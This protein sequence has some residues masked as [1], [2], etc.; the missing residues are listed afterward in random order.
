MSPF[1]LPPL[2]SAALYSRGIPPKSPTSCTRQVNFFFAK[3]VQVSQHAPP[4][5]AVTG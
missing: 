4:D 3:D 2:I 1:T 5:T